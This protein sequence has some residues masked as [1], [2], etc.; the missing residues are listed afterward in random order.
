MQL[1]Q[2]GDRWWMAIVGV[3]N[4]SHVMQTEAKHNFRQSDLKWL[5]VCSCV[6]TTGNAQDPLSK[7]LKEG[8]PHCIIG[9]NPVLGLKS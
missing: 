6:L 8:M 3:D 1:M 2:D 9:K 5:T 4:G 7:R